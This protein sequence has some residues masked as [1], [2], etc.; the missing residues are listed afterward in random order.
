[1]LDRYL[2]R[3]FLAVVDQGN[4]SRAAGHCNVSQ[5]TLSVGIAKLERI[6]GHA[7][8]VRSNQRVELTDAGSRL[9]A[10]AR[11][12]EREFNLA[13]QAMEPASA[14]P[15]L[16]LGVLSTIPARA[17]ASA[18]ATARPQEAYRFELV[19]GSERE[20]TGQL[21][22][23]RIDLA[24]AL[25]ERGADRFLERSILSEGY[26]LAMAQGHPLARAETIEAGQLV[27]EVMIVRRHCEAL[28]DISRHF[29]ERGVRP[30]FSLRSTNDERV[31]EMVAAG[32]GL[33]V[34][35]DC[36]AHDGVARPR[37][38]GFPDK[39]TIGWMA[40]HHAEHLLAAPGEIIVTIES[41]LR[42]LREK[43]AG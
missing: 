10:H 37:L 3:Y 11:R 40:A 18:I 24:L 42:A 12:I 27:H 43:A 28:S 20:L 32:L 7:L 41:E 2:L 29:T 21:A 6:L 8:F 39:R 22:K 14:L 36:Y 13:Q 31:L 17:I 34:M 25:V 16:R 30:H 9:L 15:S 1:M 5:P 4:F 26:A 19:F 23:G 35:P 33:T 38:A